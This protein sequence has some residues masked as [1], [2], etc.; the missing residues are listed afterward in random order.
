MQD[1][2]LQRGL[3]AHLR[4]VDDRGVESLFAWLPAAH[5]GAVLI[6]SA[7]T[8]QGAGEL[9]VGAAEGAGAA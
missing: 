1:V 8:G 6:P 5:M 7:P 9:L 3:A 2:W 4:A